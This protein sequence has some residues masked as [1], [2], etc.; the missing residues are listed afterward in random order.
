MSTSSPGPLLQ[1]LDVLWSR[2][3]VQVPDLP[4]AR[5]SVAP[6]PPSAN[7][8]PERWQKDPDGTVSG[9]VVDAETLRRGP[10]AVLE[11]VLHHAAHMLAWTRGISDTTMRGGYHNAAYLT[12]AEE[13]GFEWTDDCVRTP[14]QGYASPSLTDD[15]RAAYADEIAAVGEAIP[16][17]L[18]HL[19]APPPPRRP[20]PDRLNLQCK[21]TPPRKL[22]MSKTVAALGPITCGVCG[23][24]FEEA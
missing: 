9:L 20:T 21:C 6:M 17:V 3:R 18:P 8:G 4:S 24:D 19:V 22:R 7:H 11:A 14:S 13:V 15:T 5:I 16:Q 2:L 12:A 1:A 23:K 10:D